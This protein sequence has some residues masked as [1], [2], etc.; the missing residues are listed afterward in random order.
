MSGESARL[1]FVA[2]I[3][4][5][6][7]LKERFARIKGLTEVAV[8]RRD[9][10]AEERFRH[11]QPEAEIVQVKALAEEERVCESGDSLVTV[12]EEK[13][14]AE[15]NKNEETT[16]QSLTNRNVLDIKQR[17][18]EAARIV[19]GAYLGHGAREVLRWRYWHRLACVVQCAVRY[20]QARTTWRAAVTAAANSYT[21]GEKE[22]SAAATSAAA[23]ASKTADR[24]LKSLRKS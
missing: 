17:A 4:N 22:A 6:F 12:L 9:A 5:L 15:K 13:E 11:W 19:L 3:Q 7:E 18:H 14:A 1:E 20:H 10:E 2:Q 24:I 21:A 16:I 23:A 8:Q